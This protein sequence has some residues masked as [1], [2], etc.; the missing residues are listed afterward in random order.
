MEVRNSSGTT[1][2]FK[3]FLM[4]SR[5]MYCFTLIRVKISTVD[6]RSIR[7]EISYSYVITGKLKFISG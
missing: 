6:K 7:I 5:Q 1:I 3:F 4:I 2:S